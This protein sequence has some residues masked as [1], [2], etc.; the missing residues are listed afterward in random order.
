MFYSPL[1][2]VPILLLAIVGAWRLIVKEWIPRVEQLG[3]VGTSLSLLGALLVLML[4]P[5]NYPLY[6]MAAFVSL[7]FLL[8]NGAKAILGRLRPMQG[9]QWFNG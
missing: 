8:W 4:L 7:A 5:L 3:P 6:K 2:T 9:L 1:F